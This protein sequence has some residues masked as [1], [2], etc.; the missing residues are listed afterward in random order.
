MFD[1]VNIGFGLRAGASRSSLPIVNKS[2]PGK[3]KPAVGHVIVSINGTMLDGSY[4]PRA[5]A[6]KLI[7]E[8]G[9]PLTVVFSSTSVSSGGLGKKPSS[10]RRASFFAVEEF[11]K[12]LIKYHEPVWDYDLDDAGGVDYP[13]LEVKM[14]SSGAGLSRF[15]KLGNKIALGNNFTSSLL[16]DVQVKKAG[17]PI[18]KPSFGERLVDVFAKGESVLDGVD[19]PLFAGAD[20]NA[21]GLEVPNDVKEFAKR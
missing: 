21:E 17:T 6:V 2:P 12:G 13:D 15:K 10:T 7:Q 4:D 20:T 18:R 14:A 11:C 16:E 5:E 9:R 3:D 19:N 8:A 1:G